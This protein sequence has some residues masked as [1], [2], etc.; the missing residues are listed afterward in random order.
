MAA[1]WTNISD[2]VFQ[3]AKSRPRD[4]AVIE[5]PTS[6]TFGRFAELVA[7]AT[8]FLKQQKIKSGDRV[9]IRMTNSADHLI[10]SL[11]LLRIGAVKFELS[12]NHPPKDLDEITRKFSLAT[13]LVEP[14]MKI[15]RN[16]RTII[17]DTAW[18]ASIESLNGDIRHADKSGE[19]WYADLSGR[20][21]GS[22]AVAVRH[23]QTIARYHELV[24]GYGATGIISAKEPATFLMFGGM[25]FTGLHAMLLA[26]MMSGATIVMLPEFLRF[27]D[28]VRNFR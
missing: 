17:I 7:K 28:I 2:A 4:V 14:P 11:A 6:L 20:A 12:P 3:H 15:Y 10:L 5:G 26:Q 27:Y 18:R 22:R 23:A 16:A 21:S 24:A 8:V 13:L 1:V 9:G 25:Y 19:P